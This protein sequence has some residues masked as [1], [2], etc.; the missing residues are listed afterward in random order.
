MALHYIRLAHDKGDPLAAWAL[1]TLYEQGLGVPKDD[2]KA[3]SLYR[4]AADAGTPQAQLE[5]AQRHVTGTGVPR[6]WL[7]AIVLM[8]KSCVSSILL[9][10]PVQ[11]VDGPKQNS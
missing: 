11:Q 6:N 3:V 2:A 8:G 1:A 4:A 10:K 9:S 5:L 7:Q